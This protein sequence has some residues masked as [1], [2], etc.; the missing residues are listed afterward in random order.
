M[1]DSEGQERSRK[2][3]KRPSLPPSVNAPATKRSFSL[4]R[5]FHRGTKS[6]PKPDDSVDMFKSRGSFNFNS[7]ESMAY[8]ENTLGQSVDSLPQSLDFDT[9]TE[10]EDAQEEEEE[11]AEAKAEEGTRR[12]AVRSISFLESARYRGET[13]VAAAAAAIHGGPASFSPFA[14]E[15]VAGEGVRPGAQ[16]MRSQT[17]HFVA[18]SSCPYGRS[19]AKQLP[20]LRSASPLQSQQK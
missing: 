17:T 8:G 12:G 10:L 9:E 20:S 18:P 11:E 6:T 3:K 1:N 4:S 5:L 2:L 16:R 13:A 15:E 19:E 7:T 14:P